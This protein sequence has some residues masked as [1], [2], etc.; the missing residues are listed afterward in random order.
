MISHF[1]IRIK[2]GEEERWVDADK[3]FTH[4]IQNYAKAELK[5]KKPEPYKDKV[6]SF[7]KQIDEDWVVAL[8]EAYPNVDIEQE[9]ESSKMWLLSNTHQ[10]KSNFKKFINNWMAKSMRSGKVETPAVDGRSQYKKYVTPD[11][12]DE[13]LASPEEINEL[14]QGIKNKLARRKHNGNK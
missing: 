13:D 14:M 12:P 8:K 10:A 3:V 2:V 9:L 1:K 6:N 11:I 5:G 7:F 4:L